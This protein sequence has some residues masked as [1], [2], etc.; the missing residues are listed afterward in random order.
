MP[1]TGQPER[2]TAAGQPGGESWLVDGEGGPQRRVLQNVFCLGLNI[3]FPWGSQTLSNTT[4]IKAI[5]PNN[6]T[7]YFIFYLSDM[8]TQMF[9][10]DVPKF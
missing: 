4:S 2:Q 10:F 9:W 8:H 3:T 7:A 1:S 5:H 6:E